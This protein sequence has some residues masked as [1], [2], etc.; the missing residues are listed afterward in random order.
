MKCPSC[1]TEVQSEWKVCPHCAVPLHHDVNLKQEN[2]PNLQQ[3]PNTETHS[4]NSKIVS[5]IMI[6]LLVFFAYLLFSSQSPLSTTMP[7]TTSTTSAPVIEKQTPSISF[8]NVTFRNEHGF[9]KIIGEATNNSSK[10]Y[11]SII[12]TITF[13]DESGAILN[14][15]PIVIGNLSSGNTKTWDALTPDFSKNPAKYKIQVDG[16]Y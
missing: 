6:P 14:S 3:P 12:A 5:A 4:N 11:N 13:Y 9:I 7:K 15:A 8:S 16:G 10:N 1:E 2:P